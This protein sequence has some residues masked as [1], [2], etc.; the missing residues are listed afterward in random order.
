MKC[1]HVIGYVYD[2]Y[3]FHLI[4]AKP[5]EED[6]VYYNVE[7]RFSYCPDCGEKL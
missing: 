1:N 7:V 2:E 5:E 4:H 3:E 6:E